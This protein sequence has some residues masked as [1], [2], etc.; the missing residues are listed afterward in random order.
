MSR[1]F[2]ICMAKEGRES[3]MPGY[4]QL[5]ISPP[6]EEKDWSKAAH[7][8]AFLTPYPP[9]PYIFWTLWTWGFTG[10]PRTW[11]K[12]APRK[13]WKQTVFKFWAIGGHSS[14]PPIFRVTVA[15]LLND[16]HEKLSVMAKE[17]EWIVQGLLISC[18]PT[19]WKSLG[20]RLIATW[21]GA[22][23]GIWLCQEQEVLLS[24]EWRRRRVVSAWW[25][26]VWF[27]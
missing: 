25:E 4:G 8:Q 1:G 3:K 5:S 22:N 20:G 26:K 12:N 18:L 15:Q 17:G 6:L 21:R 23:D 13:A 24:P 27:Q 9:L 19:N 11:G 10:T 16:L 14:P 2:R 7:N